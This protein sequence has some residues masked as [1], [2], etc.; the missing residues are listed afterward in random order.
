MDISYRVRRLL[1]RNPGPAILILHCGTNDILNMKSKDLRKVI[2]ENLRDLRRL[3]PDT[4]IIWSEI[5]PRLFYY[6]EREMGAGLRTTTKINRHA[7]QICFEIGNAH[8]IR[9]QE[10]FPPS[11]YQFFRYDGVHLSV[12][13]NIRF[14]QNL[15]NALQY[16]SSFP[17]YLTFPPEAHFM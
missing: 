3:L 1:N 4:K 13:G 5:L 16:F 12:V 7:K 2:R 14:R 15:E 17:Y 10:L 9:H 6:G 11:A 8:V